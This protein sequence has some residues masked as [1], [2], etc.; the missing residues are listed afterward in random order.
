MSDKGLPGQ[1]LD[2][3]QPRIEMN[4]KQNRYVQFNQLKF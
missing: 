3:K 4:G 1:E 2:L